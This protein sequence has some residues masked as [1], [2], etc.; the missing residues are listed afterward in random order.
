VIWLYATEKEVHVWPSICVLMQWN[1]DLVTSITIL[2]WVWVR[3]LFIRYSALNNSLHLLNLYAV[4]LQSFWLAA[5]ISECL[6]SVIF[7]KVIIYISYHEFVLCC[8]KTFPSKW[9][10]VTAHFRCTSQPCGTSVKYVPF[11]CQ[12]VCVN[13]WMIFNIW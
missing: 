8:G 7:V 2:T 10:T 1:C 6:K 9:I 5:V 3:I 13:C 4:N 11:V 12:A